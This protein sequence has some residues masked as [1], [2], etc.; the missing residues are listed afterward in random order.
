MKHTEL[1]LSEKEYSSLLDTAIAQINSGRSAIAVQVNTTANSTYWN[2]GKLLY[3]RKIEG[4]YGSNVI[5]R[6]SR[7]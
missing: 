2:L 7:D 1:S 4:G 3:D 5:N 6:L